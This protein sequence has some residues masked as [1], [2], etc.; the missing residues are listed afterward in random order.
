MGGKIFVWLL[1][2]LFLGTVF[3]ADA[4]QTKKIPRIGFL[5][6]TP[7]PSSTSS[8]AFQQGLHEL[9]YVEGK[10][11]AI[12]YRYAAGRIDRLPEM[13][14]ELVRLNVDVIVTAATPPSQ[15]AKD[16]TKTIPIV[17]AAVGDP[18]A[19]GLVASLAK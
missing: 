17:M 9:G 13:A 16:A 4:Q 8:G 14:A 12:E 18:V 19:T 15:A 5:S 3:L 10:N 7:G 2:T 11:I 1:P 6:L